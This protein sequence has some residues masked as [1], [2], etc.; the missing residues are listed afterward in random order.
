L[1]VP[2]GSFHGEGK[3]SAMKLLR[4]NGKTEIVVHMKSDH[5]M[6]LTEASE[7][8]AFEANPIE[9][10]L[11]KIR[12]QLGSGIIIIGDVSA[13]SHSESKW[14]SGFF[15]DPKQAFPAATPDKT[16]VIA[17]KSVS[18][19]SLFNATKNLHPSDN[20]QQNTHVTDKPLV[21]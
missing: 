2:A 17:G 15:C 1:E 19:T 20:N 10:A 13:L 18:T 7:R 6:K 11:K 9:E 16:T 21:I 12:Q 4:R 14:E 5:R 3:H 8:H